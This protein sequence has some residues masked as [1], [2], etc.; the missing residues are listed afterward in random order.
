MSLPVTLLRAFTALNVVLLAGLS[1]IWIGNYRKFRSKHT[2]GLA[3]FAT[4]LLLENLMTVYVFVIDPRLS[5][6]ITDISPLA[7]RTMA[8]LKFF[9]F[10]GLAILSYATWD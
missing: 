8:G 1:F 6:W 2:L 10:V 4:F 5:V 9:Q 3:L 7:Q